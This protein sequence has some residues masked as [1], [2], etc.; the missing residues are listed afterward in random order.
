MIFSSLYYDNAV[1][2]NSVFSFF[3][4]L[5]I[6]QEVDREVNAPPEAPDYKSVT[7]LDYTIEDF[8]PT[9]PVPT[10]VSKLVY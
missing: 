2:Q 8:V 6:S 4:H 1:V 9:K 7:N 3:F 5:L 10:A